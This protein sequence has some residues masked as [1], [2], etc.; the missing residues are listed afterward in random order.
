MKEVES[1]WKE[2]KET[3]S[4]RWTSRAKVLLPETNPAVESGLSSATVTLRMFTALASHHPNAPLTRNMVKGRRK[5][6]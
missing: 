4:A 1:N 6:G 3:Y 2:N 5:E